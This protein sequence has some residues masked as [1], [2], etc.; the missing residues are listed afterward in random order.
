MACRNC[1]QLEDGALCSVCFAK[2]LGSLSPDELS[3]AIRMPKERYA[4]L[5]TKWAWIDVEP[6]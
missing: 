6:N 1:V 5:V 3:K 2:F 4:R